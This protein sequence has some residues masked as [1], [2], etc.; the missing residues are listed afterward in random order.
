MINA[1][2]KGGDV[3]KASAIRQISDPRFQVTGGSLTTMG[4]RTYLVFGQD[5][6]GGYSLTAPPTSFTQIYSDEIRSFKIVDNGKRLVHRGLRRCSR[7]HQLPPARW[8][9]VISVVMTNGSAAVTYYGGVF[10]AGSTNQTAYQAPILIGA[11]GKTQ[12]DSDYQQFFDQYTRIPV[13][14]HEGDGHHLPRGDQR[15]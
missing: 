7:F 15:L 12:V 11:N 2:I 14:R 10:T 13:S 5:F 4:G 6:Q 1:V 8:Q 9:L 3:A